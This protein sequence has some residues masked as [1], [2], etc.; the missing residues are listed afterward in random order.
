MCAGTIAHDAFEKMGTMRIIST[1]TAALCCGLIA[2]A[3]QAAI[4]Q[5]TMGTAAPATGSAVTV[6]LA[7]AK[8]SG[9]AG[10]AI[11]SQTG[12]DVLV[13]LKLAPSNANGPSAAVAKIVH[14]TCGAGT[15]N[16]QATGMPSGTSSSAAGS[17][18][19]GMQLSPMT[20]GSSQTT[21]HGVHL[22]Q[23]LAGGYSIVVSQQPPLCGDLSTA[24][25]NSGTQ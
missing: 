13:T 10:Q 2:A 9:P 14:A 7:T 3:A 6:N 20:N 23:L 11:L 16:A 8:G 19:G 24:N 22:Q 15:T 4:A 12:N 1:M 5:Q 21:L 18:G 17:A 25:G